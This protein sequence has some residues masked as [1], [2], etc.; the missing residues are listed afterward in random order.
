M[1]GVFA[2]MYGSVTRQIRSASQTGGFFDDAS[3]SEQFAIRFA[4]RYFEAYDRDRDGGR[5]TE[6]W[7]VAFRATEKR[8]M[9]L[10]HLMMGMNAHINLDL[11]IVTA[12]VAG[13]HMTDAYP[14]FL[15][16]NEVLFQMVDGLQDALAKV[17]PKMALLDRLGGSW[18]ERLMRLGIR[19]ARDQAWLFADHLER[20][21]PTAAA[22]S[23]AS[24]DQDTAGVGLLI[25]GR[26][27]RVGLVSRRI[28][29]AEST[30]VA[31]I[32][33]SLSVPAVDLVLADRAVGSALGKGPGS[34]HALPRSRL[35]G[36]RRAIGRRVPG[37]SAG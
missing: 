17:S 9:I 24:R 1:V 2:A 32:V 27:S 35:A 28:A 18:D 7:R 5:P 3:Q 14:D 36:L 21:D 25:G 22:A 33:A 37:R 20:S 12:D 11:G 6:S 13:G 26:W 31:E 16:V 29:A 4:D 19:G 30:D 8:L 10:Q 34:A 15:R 23:I